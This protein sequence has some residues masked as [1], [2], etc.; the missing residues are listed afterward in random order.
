METGSVLYHGTQTG[1]TA[2]SDWPEL[3]ENKIPFLNDFQRVAHLL[4][5]VYF[6]LF[7]MSLFPSGQLIL[8]STFDQE[9]H[10]TRIGTDAINQSNH[11]SI[12]MKFCMRHYSHKRI[13]DAKFESGSFS[14]FGDMTSQIFS[15]K[16]GTRHWILIFTP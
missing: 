10:G 16:K 14:I 9:H 7:S 13:P 11:N 15:P 4:V 8:A 5:T 2:A 1:R 12:E 6:L 3:N